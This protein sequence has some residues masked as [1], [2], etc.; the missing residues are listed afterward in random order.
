MEMI[1][2]VLAAELV[3]EVR[4]QLRALASDIR[5]DPEIVAKRLLEVDATERK[6]RLQPPHNVLEQIREPWPSEI[7]VRALFNMT[8]RVLI[9]SGP[10][11]FVTTDNPVFFF[12]G[13]GLAKE[14]SE[15]TFPLST[16]HALHGS[17]KTAGSNLMS[18]R[19]TQ[20]IVKEINR[21]LAS[22]TERLAFCSEPA[23]WLLTILLKKHLHLSV[24][25]WTD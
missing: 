12:R 18:H 19:A 21:R 6:F 10:Q 5:A 14:K 13:F 25:Q 22:E 23:P 4:G 2:S 20:V 17:W 3:A 8:W 1:P 9:S 24:I 11:Y 16:T 7:M 15:L